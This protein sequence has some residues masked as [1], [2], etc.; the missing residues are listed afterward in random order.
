RRGGDPAPQG[1][2]GDADHPDHRSLRPRHAGRSREGARGRVRRV[3][4]QAGQDAEPP[5]QD[6]GA[7]AGGIAAL[8]VPDAAI[9]V[10]DDNAD[11]RYTLC[12]RVRPEG[13]SDLV[14]AT[15]G[16]EALERVATRPFDL[17]VVDI[18]MPVLDGFEVL[19]R[20]MAPE[21]WRHVPVI[22]IPALSEF[23]SVVRSIEMGTADYL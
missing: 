11:N 9:L 10:V 17:V 8:S 6:P 18:M 12:R 5:G 14:A 22:L 2:R 16:R 15:N 4:R 1:G 13:Y 3:R 23:E 20:L 19:E 7:A 21:T